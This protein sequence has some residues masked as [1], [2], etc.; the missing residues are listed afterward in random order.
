MKFFPKIHEIREKFIEQCCI[1]FVKMDNCLL[2]Y[3]MHVLKS[4]SRNFCQIIKKE[5][6][7]AIANFSVKLIWN[8][9]GKLTIIHICKIFR[10]IKFDLNE[11]N[12]KFDFTDLLLK[13]WNFNNFLTIAQ[14]WLNENLSLEKNSS[15]QLFSKTI[16]FTKF[17]YT[18]SFYLWTTVW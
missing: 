14:M 8:S 4:I 1:F 18:K 16:A 13:N 5:S 9:W 6:N 11:I 10:E 12:E 2:Y 3:L 17:L 15:N 7:S